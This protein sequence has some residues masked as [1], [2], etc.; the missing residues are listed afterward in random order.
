MKKCPKIQVKVSIQTLVHTFLVAILGAEKVEFV[1]LEGE[2]AQKAFQVIKDD[3]EALFA[4]LKNKKGGKGGFKGNRGGHDRRAPK[5]KKT[6]FT[7]DGEP[8]EKKVKGIVLKYFQIS[9]FEKHFI[10]FCFDSVC[11]THDKRKNRDRNNCCIALALTV[12]FRLPQLVKFNKNYHPR[13]FIF[14]LLEVVMSETQPVEVKA[15]VEGGG[16]AG[17]L[18]DKGG[19]L[20]LGGG[21][22][23][24]GGIVA[25]MGR[26]GQMGS[27]GLATWARR[28]YTCKL[29]I[30]CTDLSYNWMLEHLARRNDFSSHISLLTQAEVN[31]NQVRDIKYRYKPAPGQ[32]ILWD[33]WI[34]IKIERTRERPTASQEPY[35]TIVIES[36]QRSKADGRA[37]MER[38]IN[39][40]REEAKLDMEENSTIQVYGWYLSMLDSDR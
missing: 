11:I 14:Y 26:L 24:G 22:A 28:T 17:L 4:R 21:A 23:L 10:T 36:F 27:R 35:E 40:A 25:M 38:L 34:P 2:D 13:Q 3:R 20:A 1:A 6:T 30:P 8:A 7:D 33:G 19:A 16:I 18:G 37:R 32:H 31:N 5:N 29:E 12:V 9:I 15:P 39:K